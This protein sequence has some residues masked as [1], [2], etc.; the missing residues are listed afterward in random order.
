MYA[1]VRPTNAGLGRRWG[2]TSTFPTRV[3][4]R[5]SQEVRALPL[6]LALDLLGDGFVRDDRV[7]RRAQD[8]VVEGLAGDDVANRLLNVRRLLDV[9]GS[10]ARPHAVGR[11]ARAVCGSHQTHAAGGE[12]DRHVAVLHELLGALDRHGLHPA[13]RSLGRSR[14]ERRLGHDLRDACDAPNR[15]GMRADD[16]RTPGLEGNQNLV[17]GRRGRIGGRDHRGDDAERLRDLDDFPRLVAT[18]HADGPDR[19]DEA[20][21][22][23]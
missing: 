16:D 2:L 8:A 20:V 6:E 14:A 17:D 13:D 11:F 5:R 23:F 12:D 18:D 9:G 15:G 19:F 3:D 1:A 7:L 4:F 21:D 10:V 22:L